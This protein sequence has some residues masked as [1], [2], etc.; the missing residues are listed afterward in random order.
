MFWSGN[1]LLVFFL[2]MVVVYRLLIDK[3]I[4]N[5]SKVIFYIGDICSELWFVNFFVC[6]SSLIEYV[7]GI[8]RF[9]II[10]LDMFFI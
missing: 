9:D 8:K 4:E 1:V 10:Y 7:S 2:G 6:N 5:F 3:V